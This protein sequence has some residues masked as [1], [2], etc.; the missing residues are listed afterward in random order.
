MSVEN[1]I[2]TDKKQ[3]QGRNRLIRIKKPLV[4]REQET[5][6]EREKA[7]LEA[8]EQ[9]NQTPEDGLTEEEKTNRK[10]QRKAGDL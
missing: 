1:G 7:M 2:S 9:V 5:E 3:L 6:R 8:G 10:P 4:E